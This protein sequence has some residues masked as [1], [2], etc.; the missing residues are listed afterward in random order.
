MKNFQPC[1]GL[2]DFSKK[3]PI[4]LR[5][6][7]FGG[8][9]I[10]CATLPKNLTFKDEFQERLLEIAQTIWCQHIPVAGIVEELNW[11]YINIHFHGPLN[12]SANK[13]WTELG[14]SPR[15]KFMNHIDCTLVPAQWHLFK[16]ICT[17]QHYLTEFLWLAFMAMPDI[18]PLWACIPTCSQVA[19]FFRG[20][21][22]EVQ[23]P[24]KD[25]HVQHF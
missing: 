16:S 23:N 10:P 17:I 11:R 4:S 13:L 15:N 3:I 25:R 1:D 21:R 9:E 8:W 19:N 14:K 2:E 7:L 5:W 24:P 20:W 22:P 6:H 18:S 12:V